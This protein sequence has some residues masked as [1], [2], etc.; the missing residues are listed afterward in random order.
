MAESSS[1]SLNCLNRGSRKGRSPIFQ[2]LPIFIFLITVSILHHISFYHFKNISLLGYKKICKEKKWK[3]SKTTF[4]FL[5]KKD[6]LQNNKR[7]EFC[8]SS[9]SKRCILKCYGHN[10][11]T[12]SIFLL[13]MHISHICLQIYMRRFVI[14]DM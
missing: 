6:K 3:S 14:Q 7:A 4:P 13:Q 5:K 10:I 9:K 1:H 11:T 8:N 12:H 2:L